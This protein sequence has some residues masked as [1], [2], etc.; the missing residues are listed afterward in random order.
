VIQAL[1]DRFMREEAQAQLRAEFS[2]KH[3]ESYLDVVR[4]VVRAITDADEYRAPDPERIHQID[5]G[6]YQ[7]TLVFVIAATGYQPSDY[8]YVKV[9]YGSCS[10]CDTLQ[11][12]SSYSDQPPTAEQ[13]R[14]YLT[15]ALHVA[16]G[17]K[18][19]GDDDA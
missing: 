5:D 4:A 13:V 17:L 15:L 9:N 7:G 2:A 10:G 3:P 11:A 14:D 12:I 18:K 6:D 16:Q 8:W 19:M 1:I